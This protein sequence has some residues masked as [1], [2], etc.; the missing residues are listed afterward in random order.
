MLLSLLFVSPL[1]FYSAVYEG[2]L[3]PRACFIFLV[4]ALIL[5]LF[6]IR[7]IRQGIEF[8]LPV[9]IYLL[10]FLLAVLLSALGAKD[11]P[12]FIFNLS[13]LLAAYFIYFVVANL[14]NTPRQ[15]KVFL[16]VF[17][18]SAT[19][20]AVI[21]LI[22]YLV[23]RGVVQHFPYFPIPYRPAGLRI[24]GN[25]VYSTFGQPNNMGLYLSLGLVVCLHFL[26]ETKS[27]VIGRKR[28]ITVGMLLLGS[29]IFFV[30]DASGGLG[31]YC[32]LAAIVIY[33][34]LGKVYLGAS[35]LAARKL[36]IGLFILVIMVTLFFSQG[37]LSE[38]SS[39]Q[40]TI[41]SMQYTAGQ[42]NYSGSI[43]NRLIYWWTSL[44]IFRRSPLWGVGLGQFG[45]NYTPALAG[46]ILRTNSEFLKNHAYPANYAHNEFLQFLA[47]TGLV[48][49]FLF[50]LIW[51]AVFKYTL[52]SLRS[53]PS[54]LLLLSGALFVPFFVHSLLSAPFRRLSLISLFAFLLAIWVRQIPYYKQRNYVVSN[55][56]GKLLM[57]FVLL[58]SLTII[59]GVYDNW[60]A[61]EI[62]RKVIDSSKTE[63]FINP[64]LIDQIGANP[65]FKFELTAMVAKKALNLGVKQ[66][67]REWVALA[68]QLY[69]QVLARMPTPKYCRYM[70]IACFYLGKEQEGRQYI[71]QGLSY[72]P[73]DSDLQRM[74]NYYQQKKQQKPG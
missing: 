74:L 15:I 67:R 59:W 6:L 17:L 60:R 42:A 48:G 66:R 30:L 38:T 9:D 51:F 19:I 56:L 71:N 1:L 46:L 8:S 21:G 12:T 70:A 47:E 20:V 69:Q 26:L 64:A 65:Y 61:A 33:L 31:I 34:W 54:P 14:I 28:I 73:W 62:M 45:L 37:V 2:F 40:R 23:Y 5:P 43:T 11:K 52:K 68:F 24:Y 39:L 25:R 29:L 44:E 13:F 53:N 49:F 72:V 63:K 41:S 57:P 35:W 27:A 16:R 32:G 36:R 55:K 4:I 7:L 10:G 58:L 3:L 50:G 22:Q 18:V